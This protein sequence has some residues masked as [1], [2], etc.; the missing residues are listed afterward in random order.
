MGKTRE[1]VV[2]LAAAVALALG[3]KARVRV[4]E[5]FMSHDRRPMSRPHVGRSYTVVSRK[6]TRSLRFPLIWHP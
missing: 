1:A 6:T 2:A 5:K 3:M 4:F